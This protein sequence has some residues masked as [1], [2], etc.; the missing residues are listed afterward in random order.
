MLLANLPAADRL[1]AQQATGSWMGVED[2]AQ[3]AQAA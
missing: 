1:A 3:A 2:V